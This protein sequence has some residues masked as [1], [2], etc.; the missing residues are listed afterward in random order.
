MHL[1]CAHTQGQ[2]DGKEKPA[3]FA[4]CAFKLQLTPHQGHETLA[5]GHTQSGAAKPARGAGL[6]L[7]EAAKDTG[8]VLGCNADTGIAQAEFQ[9]DGIATTLQYPDTQYDLATLC[10]FD[11]IAAQVQ[12][13]LLQAHGITHHK[14]G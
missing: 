11:G 5:D 14:V 1:R 2:N 7:G 3:T 13:H 9:G 8:L 12:Q 6:S 4:Q 10:E